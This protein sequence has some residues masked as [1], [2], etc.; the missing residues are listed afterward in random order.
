MKYLIA[1]VNARTR[2][3]TWAK[4]VRETWLPLVP[5]DKADAFF[6]V[7][8]G[9]EGETF[10]EDTVVLDCDDSYMGLPDKIREIVRW[11]YEHGYDYVLKCD[12][13]VV[14]DVNKLFESGFDRY[15]YTGRS[16]RQPTIHDPFWVPMGFNYWMS[17]K[18][19]AVIKD[20]PLPGG[21]TNDD[22]YWV[23]KHLHANG[24]NLHS[25]NNYR[26]KYG[27][28]INR[29]LRAN[30]PLRKVNIDTEPADG[31]FSWCIF[32]EGN[33]GNSIP[34]EHKLAEFRRVF[35]AFC[36]PKA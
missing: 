1:I 19:M 31:S 24:I 22:E 9:S 28:V 20:T 18:C 26:L 21:G 14:L 7:G 8:R 23:A 12:D 36:N 6:F 11:A 29:P 16:N 4:A 2:Q 15:E 3:N 17:R 32:L 25:D 13:D 35:K 10:P 33:S 27:M 34:I 5:R 30:R